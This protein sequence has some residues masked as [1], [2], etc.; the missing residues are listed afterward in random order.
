MESLTGFV[1]GDAWM[2][3]DDGTIVGKA[4]DKSWKEIARHG[5]PVYVLIEDTPSMEVETVIPS[6]DYS[7]RA[8]PVTSERVLTHKDCRKTKRKN[9]KE[10]NS[11]RRSH[12][13]KKPMHPRTLSAKLLP[14]YD[15]LTF[16]ESEEIEEDCDYEPYEQSQSYFTS[17]S[18]EYDETTSSWIIHVH[19]NDPDYMCSIWRLGY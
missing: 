9:K 6:I 14:N 3:L 5:T 17:T 7:I 19:T 16:E 11:E 8:V 12:S 2:R 13:N 15:R 10:K 4:R 1:D 18:Y